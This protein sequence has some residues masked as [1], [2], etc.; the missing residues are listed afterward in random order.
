M[1]GDHTQLHLADLS[2]KANGQNAAL[3][4][5]NLASKFIE[6]S[7]ASKVPAN[8]FIVVDTHADTLTG[9]L[10]WAGGVTAVRTAAMSELL[11]EFCGKAFLAKV[12]ESATAAREFQPPENPGWYKDSPFFRG[13][14]RGLLL[15]TCGPAVRIHAGFDDLKRLVDGCVF[16]V[17]FASCHGADGCCRDRFDFVLA[18]AG[19]STLSNHIKN[20]VSQAIEGLGVDNAGNIWETM[21]QVV[22][23]DLTLLQMNSV[24]VIYRERGGEVKCRHIGSH[25][26]PLRAWGVEFRACATQGCRPGPYDFIIRENASGVRVVCRECQW[27]SAAL[28]LSDFKGLLFRLSSAL[29]DV[30]WHEYPASAELQDLFVRVTKLKGR[31]KEG[32]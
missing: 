13:G 31:Q 29:P 25:C 21:S 11:V 9:S 4:K 28:K 27:R 14:W 23:R 5:M 12:K 7:M 19:S 17:A 18:F 3:K 30:F 22:G 24:V 26:P 8:T 6:H 16:S 10:Q 15:A 2:L 32:K 1:R 20:T